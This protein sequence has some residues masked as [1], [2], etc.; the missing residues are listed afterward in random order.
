VW[1]TDRQRVLERLWAAGIEAID[2]W[3]QG[4]EP[5][6]EFPDTRTLRRHVI[7]LPC[8]QDLGAPEIDRVGRAFR[9]AC[10]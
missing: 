10:R 8:H 4:L 1:V 6:D 2:L 9:E 3:R 5:E 7:E